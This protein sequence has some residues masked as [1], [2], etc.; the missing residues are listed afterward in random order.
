MF[1]NWGDLGFSIAFNQRP[2]QQVG[3]VS[4]THLNKRPSATTTITIRVWNT[5]VGTEVSFGIDIGSKSVQSFQVIL[6]DMPC[7]LD[8]KFKHIA[9]VTDIPSIGTQAYFHPN[10]HYAM[11]LL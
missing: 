4:V 10:Y 11:L 8:I 3:E 2:L 5:R 9:C 6:H 1:S 7:L